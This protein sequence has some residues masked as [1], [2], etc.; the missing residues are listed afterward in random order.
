[1]AKPEEAMGLEP[2]APLQRRKDDI[3]FRA[4]RLLISTRFSSRAPEKTPGEPGAFHLG[5]NQS[6]VISIVSIP[7]S[8][9]ITSIVRLLTSRIS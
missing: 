9:S 5:V 2:T 3:T 6:R 1:V 8:P 4:T 7:R